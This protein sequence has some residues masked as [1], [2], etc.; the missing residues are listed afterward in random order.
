MRKK[1]SIYPEINPWEL[2][3]WFQNP[4]NSPTLNIRIGSY[5]FLAIL[6]TILTYYFLISFLNL[7]DLA[8][9]IH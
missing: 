3:G 4:N 6:G 8:E 2:L 7:C 5:L 9:I 1:F